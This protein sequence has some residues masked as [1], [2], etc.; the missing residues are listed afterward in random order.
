M[1]FF[2]KDNAL[3][4]VS[5]KN[6]FQAPRMTPVSWSDYESLLSQH[7]MEYGHFTSEFFNTVDDISN[8]NKEIENQFGVKMYHP[9]FDIMPADDEM[10]WYEKALH[11]FGQQQIQRSVKQSFSIEAMH[12]GI[13]HWKKEVQKIRDKN[14]NQPFNTLEY[15]TDLRKKN[16]KQ[17]EFQISQM[18]MASRG[19]T[20]KWGA[21]LVSGMKTYFTDPFVLSSLPLS[22]AYSVPSNLA[23]GGLKVAAMEGLLEAGRMTAV[24]AKV[25]PYKQEMGLDYNLDDSIRNVAMATAG[26]VV[27]GPTGM[28]AFR[29]L[30]VGAKYTYKGVKYTVQSTDQFI[31]SKFFPQKFIGKELNK[32]IDQAD[33]SKS[34]GQNLDL[35]PP[36]VLYDIIQGLPDEIRSN[37]KV[38]RA[39]DHY[40]Q[41]VLENN[42]NP[43]VQD[44]NGQRLHNDHYNQ[45]RNQLDNDE[46]IELTPQDI[47][48]PLKDEI[49]TADRINNDI[50]NIKATIDE[51]NNK[52]NVE[53]DLLDIPEFLRTEKKLREL[54]KQLKILEKDKKSLLQEEKIPSRLDYPPEPKTQ[55][56]LQWLKKNKIKSDDGNIGDVKS[57]LDKSTFGYTKKGGYSLDDLLIRAREDG[58]LPPAKPG[59]PDDLSI[60]DVLDLISE[61]PVR[62]SDQIKI[63]DFDAA[64]RE[65]DAEIQLLQE[66]NVNVRGMSNEDVDIALNNIKNKVS[67]NDLKKYSD[68]DERFLDNQADDAFDELSRFFEEKGIKNNDKFEITRLDEEGSTTMTAKQV[69]DDIK[70]DKKMIDELTKCEGLQ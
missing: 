70:K 38:Q 44:P 37:P 57:I 10:P 63:A 32:L 40:E 69:M 13:E 23:L 8:V 11:S 28:L 62:E 65:I 45:A 14:P 47:N 36:S 9:Y 66:N 56:F 64:V 18:A 7:G 6:N 27:L 54:K 42:G 67:K 60:N 29:A 58:W 21:P 24:E 5:M 17:Q 26:G 51:L 3:N 15:Y 22:F 25:L 55:T 53:E 61:N 43:Y 12:S 68:L 19:F 52:L 1:D 35:A 48:T 46:T 16:A 33:L 39:V 34:L 30:P 2:G 49:V 4:E 20:E 59:Q 41:W 31:N 50:N